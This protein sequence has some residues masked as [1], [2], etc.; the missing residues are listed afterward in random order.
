V[1]RRYVFRVMVQLRS[2]GDWVAVRHYQDLTAARARACRASALSLPSA[3][4]RVDRSELVEFER[5][6]TIHVVGYYTGGRAT[7]LPLGRAT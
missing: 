2:G 1:K 3:R 5:G 7:Y 4:F 6:D